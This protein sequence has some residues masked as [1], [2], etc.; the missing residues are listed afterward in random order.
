[1]DRQNQI[2]YVSVSGVILSLAACVWAFKTGDEGLS[3]WTL[4]FLAFFLISLAAL[5]GVWQFKRWAWLLSLVLGFSALGFGLYAA[6]F[7]WHFWI[8]QE[9]TLADR[10]FALLR[11]QVL[12]FL[13]IPAAWIIYFL[14]PENR[15]LFD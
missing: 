13:V 11:P 3:P 6:H 1:M 2:R 10:F 5:K 7:A 4:S 12:L 14:K 15:H 8:F 9:P